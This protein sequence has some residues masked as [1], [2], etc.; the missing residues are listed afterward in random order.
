MSVGGKVVQVYYYK[1]NGESRVWI[2]TLDRGGEYCSVIL[3][4][5]RNVKEN[6]IVWWQGSNAYWT[7]NHA[8]NEFDSTFKDESIRKFSGSGVKHPLGKEFII[9][10]DFREAHTKQKI[11]NKTLENVI[12]LLEEDIECINMFLDNQNIPRSNNNGEKYSIIGRI[13]ILINN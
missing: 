2:N 11:K 9:S 10:Y 5:T 1:E 7:R 3:D 13:A 8:I 12:E 4:G 6:D